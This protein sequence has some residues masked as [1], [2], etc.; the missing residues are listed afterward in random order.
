[1]ISL[2]GLCDWLTLFR[3][4]ISKNSLFIEKAA[5]NKSK[6]KKSK[7][8]SVTCACHE[9]GCQ[10][11]IVDVESLLIWSTTRWLSK[12][13]CH[14]KLL[15]HHF[16]LFLLLLFFFFCPRSFFN[17]HQARNFIWL[18]FSNFAYTNSPHI[19]SLL[20]LSCLIPLNLMC[21]VS[22]WMWFFFFFFGSLVFIVPSP[23]VHLIRYFIQIMCKWFTLPSRHHDFNSFL[24]F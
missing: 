16:L 11:R 9:L 24:F 14:A 12:S 7:V 22:L 4:W 13:V 2:I 10:F 1:M 17:I 21:A 23:L 20:L 8:E 18:Y 6:E 19:W 5:N 15:I 3:L